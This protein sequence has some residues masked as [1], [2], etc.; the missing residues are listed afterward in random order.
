MISMLVDFVIFVPGMRFKVRAVR[1]KT[2]S[3]CTT[4]G[5]TQK[6][7]LPS[8]LINS[9]LWARLNWITTYKLKIAQHLPAKGNFPLFR[10]TDLLTASS[11]T[12][13]SSSYFPSLSWWPEDSLSCCSNKELQALQ[14]SLE[15]CQEHIASLTREIMS[16]SL[17]P[18]MIDNCERNQNTYIRRLN[19]YVFR[20]VALETVFF[21]HSWK[22]PGDIKIY[23][24]L[25]NSNH[26]ILISRMAW[27]CR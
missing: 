14:S 16:L 2:F 6:D 5:T 21:C 10:P 7:R 22:H 17:Q 25:N 26:C 1:T 11:L 8:A 3:P 15:F 24:K 9:A 4:S 23:K 18:F 12:E 19:V 20:R 13:V 27:L